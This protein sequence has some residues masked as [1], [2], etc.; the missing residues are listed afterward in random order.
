MK[1][2]FFCAAA[3]LAAIS[4]AA[5]SDDDD[6]V[7]L[8]IT[9]ESLAGTWQIVNETGWEI[10]DGEKDAWS[11]N[12]PDKYGQYYM[13]TF[14]KN[15]TYTTTEYLYDDYEGKVFIENY[16]GSYS[17]SGNT[18]LM[19][20]DYSNEPYPYEISKLTESVLVLF[21]AYKEPNYSFEETLT[22]KRIK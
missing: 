16:T 4:F 10:Y 6:P 1:K 14:N 20:E 11:E 3:L 12:Y 7:N 18:L 5:C 22:F 8:P 19:K 15:G 2:L 21:D 17:I 13:C 9:P